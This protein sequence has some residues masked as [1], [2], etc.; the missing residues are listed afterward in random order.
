[1]KYSI[2]V[3]LIAVVSAV[4]VAP[5][6]S[7]Q[8][9]PLRQGVSVQLADTSNAVV[10]READAA[11]A[12]IIAVTAE[13]QLYFGVKPVTPEQ[14]QEEMKATPRRR[15]AKLYIKADARAPFA[16]LKQALLAAHA[17]FFDSAVLLTQHPQD[18][19]PDSLVPPYGLEVSLGLPSAKSTLVQLGAGASESKEPELKVNDRQLPWSE[20][21]RALAQTMTGQNRRVVIIEADANLPVAQV[22]SAIDFSRSLGA[23][24]AI[25]PTP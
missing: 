18:V 21:Q 7:G 12:W 1:M 22:I 13:G 24:V 11:D 17:D 16:A 23:I 25:S 3:C 15:D 10:F 9:P 2:L 20:L 5:R 14:L 19:S 8:T 4:L 6:A